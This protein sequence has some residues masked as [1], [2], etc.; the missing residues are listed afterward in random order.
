MGCLS[1]STHGG[2][3]MTLKVWVLGTDVELPSFYGK[4]LYPQNHLTGYVPTSKE[5][6]NPNFYLESNS[7][8]KNF[9]FKKKN[10]IFN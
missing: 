3:R 7:N 8:I 2:Q 5:I 1:H 4:S 10:F 6:R 9:I